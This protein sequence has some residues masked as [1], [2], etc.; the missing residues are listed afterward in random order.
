MIRRLAPAL[1]LVAIKTTLLTGLDPVTTVPKRVQSLISFSAGPLRFATDPLEEIMA[2]P[3]FPQPMYAPLRDLSAEY[4]LPGVDLVP[5]NTLG[6]VLANHA[7]IE[8]YMVGLNHEMAR[9]LLWNDTDRS[10]R[11]LF[12]QFW[13]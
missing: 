11:Q 10:A 6:F 1:D 13:E 2:A 7:F 9:Q 3:E 8:G 4:V 5:P 12:R